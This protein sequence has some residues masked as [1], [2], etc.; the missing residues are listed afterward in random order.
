[1]L[2]QAAAAVPPGF[3]VE[4]LGIYEETVNDG[5]VRGVKVTQVDAGSAAAR[6]G[7]QVGDVIVQSNGYLVQDAGNL[8]WVI[9]H[10]ANGTLSLTVRTAGQAADRVVTVSL[11]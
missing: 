10:A 11:G 5:T 8:R 2:M 1:M 9:A 4:G 3:P 7:L 6:A